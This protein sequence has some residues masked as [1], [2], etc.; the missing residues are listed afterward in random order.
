[1]T[2]KM[3]VQQNY[4][5]YKLLYNPNDFITGI[6]EAR[7]PESPGIEFATWMVINVPIM[8]VTIFFSWV[9][10][11]IVFMGLFRPN[12]ADAKKIRIGKQGEAVANKLLKQKLEEMGP[13]SFHEIMV[14][15]M[16]LLSV[17]LWFF[18]KPQFITGW[19]EMITQHKVKK[20]NQF[21]LF[22]NYYFFFIVG[23][24]RYCSFNSSIAPIHHTLK[25]HLP[26]HLQ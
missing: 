21:S 6:Y 14:G 24:R 19:A 10:L 15:L 17:A 8:I 1:M 26:Q 3:T 20:S 11:Q 16:F 22:S 5:S 23:E 7:F 12:S 2:H 25:A 4:C 18:R 9:Y 13:M